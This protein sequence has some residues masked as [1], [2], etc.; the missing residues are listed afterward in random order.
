MI[1]TVSG[2]NP[3]VMCK[4]C[5]HEDYLHHRSTGKCYTYQWIKTDGPYP[6]TNGFRGV[7]Y[8]LEY[9]PECDCE[10]PR[11]FIKTKSNRDGDLSKW[12]S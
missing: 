2:V 7:S 9:G 5:N 4:R 1:V 3:T 10:N 6:L 12:L 8:K 11:L